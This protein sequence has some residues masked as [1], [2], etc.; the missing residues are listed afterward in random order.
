MRI[1]GPELSQAVVDWLAYKK[2]RRQSYKDTGLKALVNQIKRNAEKYGED[3]L[4]DVI[5]CS[6]ANRYEGICWSWLKE[7]PAG[8]GQ[9]QFF[10]LAKELG[11]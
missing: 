1:F 10:E 3:M 4:A 6:I 7:R 9:N 2:E 11:T 8:K 5:Q